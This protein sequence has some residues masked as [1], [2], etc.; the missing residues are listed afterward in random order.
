M[1][2]QRLKIFE[3]HIFPINSKFYVLPKIRNIEKKLNI[4]IALDNKEINQ[5]SNDIPYLKLINVGQGIAKDIRVNVLYG[6]NYHSYFEFLKAEF[7]KFDPNLK[8]SISK[9]SCCI[10]KRN[11]ENV[12]FFCGF[13]FETSTEL[14]SDYLLPIKDSEE[15][16]KIEL[17]TSIMTAIS[18][19]IFLFQNSFNERPV[20][21]FEKI[22]AELN[23]TIKAKYKDNLNKGYSESFKI[24]L[25]L[26]QL[27]LDGTTGE[28]IY[29]IN[30]NRD[31]KYFI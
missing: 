3:P 11:G 20:E 27:K 22:I 4:G 18:F 15:F 8:I 17:P 30:M 13:P 24:V 10:E 19:T 16:L 29:C 28:M 5:Y 7:E 2:T 21:L 31:N 1:K 23:I 9:S 25:D 26:P 12:E 14:K 6:F